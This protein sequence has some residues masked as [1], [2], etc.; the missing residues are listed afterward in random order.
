VKLLDFFIT[1]WQLLKLLKRNNPEYFHSKS[2][3]VEIIE[4]KEVKLTITHLL[5]I[6]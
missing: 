3:I 5:H 4:A 2:Q 6:Y 1:L